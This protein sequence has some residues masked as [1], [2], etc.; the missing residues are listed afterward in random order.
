M[1]QYRLF[2][3]VGELLNVQV[4]LQEA[5]ALFERI[6]EYLDLPVEIM[7]RPD[8]IPLESASGH[9]RFRAVH[10]RYRLEHPTL[11]DVDFEVQPGQ[12]VA[13]VGPSGAGKTTMTY[14][15]ARLYDVEQGAVE[16]DGHDVRDG[17]L[18]SLGSH[19]DKGTQEP[20]LHKATEGENITNGKPHA[21]E[22]GTKAP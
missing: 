22:Q 15:L 1:L 21:T 11:I 9:I 19:I 8:A 7:D 3:P 16:I 17:P 14:L 2:T 6:F 5:L 13:L 10:F 20:Y 4:A 12:L 18:E